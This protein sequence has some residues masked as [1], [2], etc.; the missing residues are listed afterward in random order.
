[1]RRTLGLIVCMVA[2][3]SLA[4][5][6]VPAMAAQSFL[7]HTGLILTPTSDVM[8]PGEFSL[9][10]YFLNFDRGPDSA[11][12]AA[13]GGVFPK[14]EVG[15]LAIKPDSGDTDGQINAKFSLIPETIGSPA[16][17]AGVFGLGGNSD[18]SAYVVVGKALQAPGV[19]SLAGV[20]APR[21]YLGLATGNM[22]GVFGGVSATLGDK[23]TLMIEHDTNDFNFG[24]RF[25]ISD[26]FRLHG[27]VMGGDSVG[28]GASFYA[29]F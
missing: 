3:G 17:S 19:D 13:T 29:G 25:A 9:G 4:M 27:A 12:Y 6:A 28:L 22:D 10:A 8:S 24:A 11:V 16:V 26:Q 18:T 14:L 15:V 1:M 20:G 2:L 7:G 23:L 5:S 21:V